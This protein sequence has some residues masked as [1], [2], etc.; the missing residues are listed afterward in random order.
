MR[1][2]MGGMKIRKWMNVDYIK[3][4]VRDGEKK[5]GCGGGRK[6]GGREEEVERRK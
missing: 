4:G 2:E 1:M 6:R 5:R 3:S